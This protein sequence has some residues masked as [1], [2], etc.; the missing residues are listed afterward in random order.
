LDADAT[1]DLRL[2][3]RP[4]HGPEPFDRVGWKLRTLQ[5]AER[6]IL[7]EISVKS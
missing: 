5:Q 7:R 1:E 6:A 2:D 4:T 3:S